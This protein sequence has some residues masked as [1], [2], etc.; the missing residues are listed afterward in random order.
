[1]SYRGLGNVPTPACAGTVI[2]AEGLYTDGSCPTGQALYTKTDSI[3]PDPTGAMICNKTAFCAATPPA[4]ATLISAEDRKLLG[5]PPPSLNPGQAQP[6][7]DTVSWGPWLG[8]AAF[9]AIG[10]YLWHRGS[11][12]ANQARGEWP[13]SLVWAFPDGVDVDRKYLKKPK[14]GAYGAPA[15]PPPRAYGAPMGPPPGSW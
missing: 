15:S 11:M 2:G 13:K 4:G 14:A 5:L 12:A 9:A 10:S 6:P 1:M 8:L 7:K 3:A